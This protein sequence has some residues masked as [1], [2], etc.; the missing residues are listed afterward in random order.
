MTRALE[1]ARAIGARPQETY[2]HAAAGELLE[3]YGDWGRAFAE[4]KTGLAIARELGHREW[5]AAALSS[6]GRVRRNCGDG[7]GAR[8]CHKE[9]LGIARELR[10]TLWLADALSEL[11]QDLCAAGE[12]AEGERHLT[13]AIAAAHE[14]LQ[15]SMRPRIAQLELALQTQR[16]A[17]VLDLLARLEPLLSQFDVYALDAWR[18][19]GE[20]LVAMGR[21]DEGEARLRAVKADAAALGAAPA[22]WRANLALARL[23]DA[24][25]RGAEARTARTDARRLLEKVAAGLTGAPDLLRGFQATPAYREAATP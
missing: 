7:P 1:V 20:A 5:T 6:L 25:G 12:L 14:A 9:M 2:V 15:F 16:P 24:T 11:G 21:R 17:E 23:F 3:P 18:A 22:G 10:T 13:E 8:A 19:A 4:S